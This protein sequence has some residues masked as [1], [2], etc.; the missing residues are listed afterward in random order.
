MS[1]KKNKPRPQPVQPLPQ[2]PKVEMP[3]VQDPVQDNKFSLSGF[4]MQALIIAVLGFVFYFNTFQNDYAL[5]DGIIIAKNQYVQQGFKGIPDIMG[6]DAFSSFYSSFNADNQLTGGRYRPLSIVTFAVEQELWGS[7][8]DY[9]KVATA[10]GVIS[11]QEAGFIHLMHI[12]HVVN[13][14]LF[15][16][17]VVVLLYLFRVVLFRQQPWAAFIAALLFTIHPLHTEVVA[18]VKSR[19]E[20]MSLLFICLTLIAAYRYAEL[21]KVK[22][23]LLSL[24]WFALALLSKEYAITLVVLIPMMLYLTGKASLPNSIV[25][26]LPYLPLLLLYGY[27]RYSI[28]GDKQDDAD[29]EVLTNPYLYASATEVVASKMGILLRYLQLLIFPHPLSSDYSYRQIP[30]IGMGDPRFII[31]VLVYG[32]MILAFVKLFLRKH[33]LAFAI[34]FYLGN[35][36]LV[37]NMFFNVGAPMGERLVYHSSVGFVMVVGY[38]LVMLYQRSKNPAAARMGIAA[39]LGLVVV[40]SAFKT[41]ARNADWKN[42]HTLFL[43]DVQ[44]APNSVVTNANAG[45]CY[46]GMSDLAKDTVLRRRYLDTSLMYLNKTLAM[47]HTF[48]TGYLNRGVV[49]FKLG[50]IEA[51][52]KNFDSLKI[53]FPHYPTLPQLYNLIGNYYVTLGYNGYGKL[54]KYPEAM[55]IFRKGLEADPTNADLWYNVGGAAFSM[56]QYDTAYNAWATALRYNP[57]HQ[58]AQKGFAA[59]R[60]ILKK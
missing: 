43:K 48:A 20:I 18:N 35:L 57:Q 34:A 33:M 27:L 53:V 46:I 2:A 59:V 60:A 12:R 36:A 22:W 39:A 51:A 6:K 38:L 9:S 49:Y 47:H 16:L 24:L 32:G 42:D 58:L 41:I 44:T 5:D 45:A 13:V 17:S 25:R 21:K 7:G 11:P 3:P 19:D 28:V 8:I 55:A 31:S 23:L 4:R 37:S 56:Q 14:L 15:I 29:T 1:K 10:Y 40:L 50:Q 54:G 26:V 52:K 30:Y